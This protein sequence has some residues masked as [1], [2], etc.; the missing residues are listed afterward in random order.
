MYDPTSGRFQQADSVQPNG[1]GTQGW[2][3]Y[4]Y[5]SGN[6]TTATDPTGHFQE[7]SSTT[8]PLLASRV[9]LAGDVVYSSA[10]TLGYSSVALKTIGIGSF[11]YITLKTMAECLSAI[12]IS[13]DAQFT[14]ATSALSGFLCAPTGVT[15]PVTDPTPDGDDEE[16]P[17]NPPPPTDP[18]PQCNRAV[19]G[20]IAYGPLD[21]G[22]ATSASVPARL[23]RASF[24]EDAPH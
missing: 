9:A 2:G 7:Y 23:H 5:T 24:G 20:T 16:D 3:L 22:R 17:E 19:P 4:G 1:S 15:V 12:A 10:P 18:D 13:S 14:S 21:N 6:P 11:S 8:S